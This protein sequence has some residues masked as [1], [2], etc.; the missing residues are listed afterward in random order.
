MV[1]ILHFSCVYNR[2]GVNQSSYVDTE[3]FTQLTN[4]T[5]HPSIFSFF[6]FVLLTIPRWQHKDL[7]GWLQMLLLK[8]ENC[9]WIREN[10]F[11]YSNIKFNI[12]TIFVYVKCISKKCYYIMKLLDYKVKYIL[13]QR[14]REIPFRKMHTNT[15][16]L[17]KLVNK[18]K[19]VPI[20]GLQLHFH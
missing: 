17:G 19:S 9:F 14:A 1:V 10:T 18:I 3:C 5:Q 11:V 16:F 15:V 12:D 4:L 8:T 6:S 7:C 2:F 13:L 20:N